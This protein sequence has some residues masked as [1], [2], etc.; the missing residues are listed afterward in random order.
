MI[1]FKTMLGLAIFTFSMTVSANVTMEMM[2]MKRQF[3]LLTQADTQQSF[4]DASDK[5][6]EISKQAQAK[7]PDSLVDEP[8]R[9]KGYQQA[10]Q[11]MIDLA[12]QAKILAEQG[13]L[14][15]A[16]TVAQQLDNFRKIYHK[17]YK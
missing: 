1:K 13:K 10:M 4:I 17:E 8:E 12:A 5:F 6:I 9:F 2:Q 14:D 7:M 16:K 11:E 15:E 3:N